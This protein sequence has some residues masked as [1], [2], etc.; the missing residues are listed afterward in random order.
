MNSKIISKLKKIDYIAYIFL[1]PAI[2][3]LGLF[4]VYPIIWTLLV[5]FRDVSVADLLTNGLFDIPG[6]FVFLEN[7]KSVFQNELFLKSLYNTFIYG[8]IYMPLVIGLSLSFAIMLNRRMAGVNF[9]RTVLFIPYIISVVSASLIFMFVF[10][11]QTGLINAVITAVTGEQGPN[12]LSNP[13]LAMPVI[14][15]MSVWKKVGYFMLIYLAG[16]QNI[17]KSLYESADIDGANSRQKFFNVTWPML[18]KITFVVFIM[19][20]IDVLKVFQEVYVMTGGG[21]ENST[22]TVPF[23]IYNEAFIYHRFGT[24]SAMSYILFFI[25][26]IVTV[27]Q[28]FVM[29][30]ER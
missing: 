3:V 2:I 25:V 22:V 26:V 21:P 28:R 12:W 19:S 15:V 13:N 17:S 16:L 30:R 1:I 6:T 5:S 20:L 29:N 4:L 8:V 24:A 7:Y 9:F 10:N 14:A 18:S 23:L 27:F 11:G